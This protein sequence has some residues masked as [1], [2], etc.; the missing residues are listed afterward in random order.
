VLSTTLNLAVLS[1][2]IGVAA[3]GAANF[4]ATFSGGPTPSPPGASVYFVDLK[5]GATISPK[6]T[7]HFRLRGIAV[8]HAGSDKENSGHRH[9]LIA[10]ELPSLDQ[11]IPSDFKRWTCRAESTLFSFCWETRVRFPIRR[12]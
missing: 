8:A 2:L 9:L 7:I 10:A 4:Q 11:E 5:N 6:T 1:L 3:S 12:R